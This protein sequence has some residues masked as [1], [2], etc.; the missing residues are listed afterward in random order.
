M[1]N[2]YYI[3]AVDRDRSVLQMP[4]W[5]LCPALSYWGPGALRGRAM[6]GATGNSR[7]RIRSS[8]QKSAYSQGDHIQE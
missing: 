6:A 7:A 1:V 5:A 2:H 4:R 8:S 3:Y